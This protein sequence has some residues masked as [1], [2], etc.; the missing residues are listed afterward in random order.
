M[1]FGVFR[2]MALAQIFVERAGKCRQSA[3]ELFVIA[4]EG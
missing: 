1:N 4:F 3:L 2:H